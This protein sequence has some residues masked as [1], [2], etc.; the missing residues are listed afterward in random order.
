MKKNKHFKNHLDLQV[1]KLGELGN[2][3]FWFLNAFQN[4]EETCCNTTFT[5]WLLYW[6]HLLDKL[7]IEVDKDPLILENFEKVILLHNEY[8]TKSMFNAITNHSKVIYLY[9]NALYAEISVDYDAQTIS[10]VRGHGYPQNEI[11]NGSGNPSL[12]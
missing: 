3:L 10:L 2:I 7:D 5:S 11:S 9:P 8:V 4:N 12:P 6:I 1:D